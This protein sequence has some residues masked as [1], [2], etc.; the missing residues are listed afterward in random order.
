MT[1][2]EARKRFAE[3][4]L[5]YRDINE[6]DIC[7]L[8]MLLNKELKAASKNKETSVPKLRMS[9]KIQSKFLKDGTVKCCFLFVNGSYFTQRECISFNQNGF[10]GFAGWSDDTNVAPIIKAFD[11]WVDVLVAQREPKQ[12]GVIL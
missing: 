12:L 8:V 5:T 7:V 4:G 9:L 1:R 6:G 2:D 3:A 11:Q 10:I